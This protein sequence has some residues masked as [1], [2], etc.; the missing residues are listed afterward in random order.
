M[1][2]EK[3]VANDAIGK[4]LVSKICKQLIQ[5]NNKKTTWSS[6][7][8][9]TGSLALGSAGMQVESPAQ[10][11]GLR[12]RCCHSCSLGRNY[13]SD[14]LPGSGTSYTQVQPTKKQANKQTT[15]SKNRQK[16]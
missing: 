13:G 1:E 12:I 2:W 15:Q 7:C 6:C 16:T 5:F 9:A 11:S 3:I 4:D 8:G 10:H 14:M